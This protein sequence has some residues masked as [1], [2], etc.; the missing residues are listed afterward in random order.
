ME[1]ITRLKAKNIFGPC[2]AQLKNVY[3][4]LFAPQLYRVNVEILRREFL[5][6]CQVL[7]SQPHHQSFFSRRFLTNLGTI[8]TDTIHLGERLRSLEPDWWRDDP[9]TEN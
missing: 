6:K 3:F 2:Q 8:T 1:I 5:L 9:V 7:V 4:L